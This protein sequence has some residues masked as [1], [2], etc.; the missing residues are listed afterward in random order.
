MAHDRTMHL[1]ILGHPTPQSLSDALGD[2]YASGLARGGAIVER[3]ALRDLTFDPHL[4]AGFSGTQKLEP[5]LQ[6]AQRAI[7]RADSVSWFFPTWW[8]GPPALVKGF[9]DRAF[10]PGWAFSYHKGGALPET[11]LAG[12]SA[13]V[14]TTMDSPAFW[15]RL[16]HRSSLHTSFVNATLRFVGFGPVRTSTFFEQKQRTERKRASWLVQM[17]ATGLQDARKDVRLARASGRLLGT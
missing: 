15:Y 6:T 11:L 17:E 1:V 9:I 2:A 16:W 12:R 14:V 3:L 10:L 5:D 13:R 8:G 7:E 4:R